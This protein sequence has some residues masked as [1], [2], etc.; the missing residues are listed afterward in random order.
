MRAST[1]QQIT[2]AV[3]FHLCL[4]WKCQLTAPQAVPLERARKAR[5]ELGAFCIRVLFC[6]HR[7]SIPSYTLSRGEDHLKHM[8]LARMCSLV[9]SIV[10]TVLVP[11]LGACRLVGSYDAKNSR[12][13]PDDLSH[14]SPNPSQVTKTCL[15]SP[16]RSRNHVIQPILLV[17]GCHRHDDNAGDA[18]HKHSG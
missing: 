16:S 10:Q 8:R 6:R 7:C 11:T 14:T 17:K 4:R 15:P 12:F 1:L 2:I 9:K 5:Q 3:L 13:F 18:W